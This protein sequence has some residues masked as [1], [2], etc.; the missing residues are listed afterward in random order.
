MERTN[1]TVELIEKELEGLNELIE[2]EQRFVD[3][4]TGHLD[5]VRQRISI[6]RAKKAD[7]LATLNIISAK[8]VV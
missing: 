1:Y 2:R 7:L 3:V 4:E 5:V 8:E 6:M